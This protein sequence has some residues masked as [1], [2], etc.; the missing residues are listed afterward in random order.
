[1]RQHL[2]RGA[3]VFTVGVVSLALSATTVSAGA[4]PQGPP[5]GM[6]G[7]PNHGV[8]AVVEQVA[9]NRNSTHQQS[10]AKVD[11]RQKNV[12]APVSILTHNTDM[13]PAPY[14]AAKGPGTF[15]PCGCEHRSDGV[16]QSNRADNDARSKTVNGTDQSVHQWGGAWT[17]GSSGKGASHPSDGKP[18][19]FGEPGKP[20]HPAGPR[21]VVDQQA[22]NDNS[23][24]QSSR[25]KVDNSQKNWNS[26]ISILTLGSESGLGKGCGCQAPGSRSSSGDVEQNNHA[27][28]TAK[29]ET[30]NGTDQSVHQSGDAAASSEPEHHGPSWEQGK[31]DKGHPGDGG[32]PSA[33]VKQDASNSNTTTQESSAVVDNH[34]TNIN[35]PIT[36]LSA[37]SNNGDVDQSNHADNT[38]KSETAN[39]TDQSVRQSGDATATGESDHPDKKGGPDGGSDGDAKVGQQAENHNE[40]GQRSSAEVTNDQLNVNMPITLLSA[41]SGNGDVDQSNSAKNSAS[42]STVNGTDQGITQIG[43]AVSGLLGG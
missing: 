26:P 40:T 3:L 30:V 25:A 7:T 1:M 2:V 29:S 38:A 19:K 20:G 16:T 34:Q 5:G 43:S 22:H 13:G 4:P 18:G 15:H 41:D 33:A 11:N 9:G 14:A 8:T 31:A 17:E 27:D 32:D 24:E 21:A 35:M 23:T 39:G 37:N 28:N 36:V 42:S 6:H 10:Q 12:N